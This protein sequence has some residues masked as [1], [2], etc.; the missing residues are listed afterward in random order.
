MKAFTWSEQSNRAREAHQASPCKA[1]GVGPAR[2]PKHKRFGIKFELPNR[3]DGGND[4]PWFKWYKTERARD[5][6]MNGGHGYWKVWDKD[7]LKKTPVS[8]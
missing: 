6:A 2:Q 5:D 3:S 8:R 1:P 7:G 4:G